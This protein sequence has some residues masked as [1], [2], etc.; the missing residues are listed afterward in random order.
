[1]KGFWII[2]GT[3]VTDQQAQ[4]GYATYSPI[5]GWRVVGK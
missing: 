2:L 3:E 4:A 1:M 5:H